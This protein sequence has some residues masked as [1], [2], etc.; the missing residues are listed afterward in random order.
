M[1]KARAIEAKQHI[2]VARRSEKG[3]AL[4]VAY[5]NV[6][7][8]PTGALT[9]ELMSG[10]LEDELDA[11]NPPPLYGTTPTTPVFHPTLLASNTTGMPERDIGTTIIQPTPA[12]PSDLQSDRQQILKTILDTVGPSSVTRKK[13]EFA[14]AWILDE[15]FEREHRDNWE[16]AYIII[17]DKEV[18]RHA[19]IITS[20]TI[21]KIRE[22]EDGS[23]TLKNRIVPHGNRGREKDNIR[24]DSSTAQIRRNSNPALSCRYT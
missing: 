8:A 16:R 13:L 24:K 5:E 18:P 17:D 12:P 15:A 7:D 23:K 19:N 9:E 1:F 10:T 11:A 4:K 3:P 22:Q 6:R 21:Y 14:P 2:V 20:H